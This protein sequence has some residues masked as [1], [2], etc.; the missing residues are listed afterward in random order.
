VADLF[1]PHHSERFSV[2]FETTQAI[3]PREHHE[4]IDRLAGGEAYIRICA[5]ASVTGEGH[6]VLD[7]FDLLR[8]ALR[9]L[10]ET[11]N[12]NSDDEEQDDD[13]PTYC[14]LQ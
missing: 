5:D 14:S 13:A 8:R 10:A 12:N 6:T 3:M 7:S 4:L 11:T 2:Y 1:Y 9:P